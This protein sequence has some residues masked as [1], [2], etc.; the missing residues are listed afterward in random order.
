MIGVGTLGGPDAESFFINNR[1]QVAGFSYTN[2]APNSVTG[3]PMLHPFLWRKGRMQDLGTLGGFGTPFSTVNVNG[4]NKRGQVI[5]LSPLAGDQTADPFLWDRGKLVDLATR[6]RGGTFLSANAI[7]DAGEI[8]GAA[9]FPG[10]V[11]DAS[12]WRDDVVTD[13]GTVGG[14]GCSEA[15]ALNSE[16]QIVGKSES[17]DF[18]TARAFLWENGSMIDLNTVVPPGTL[19]YLGEAN[20]ITDQ[21]AIAGQGGLPTG[22]QHSFLLIPV[23]EDDTEGCANA[24]LDPNIVIHTGGAHN[25]QVPTST[26]VAPGTP[27]TMETMSRLRAQRGGRYPGFSAGPRK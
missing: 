25:G 11:F 14:D 8:V 2:S 21:G 9:A 27:T 6:G 19:L 16:G 22:E 26:K 10:R 4:L 23:C 5:G 20:F 3:L 17:C 13:L 18:T 7:N 24:P 12:L 1:G 15:H